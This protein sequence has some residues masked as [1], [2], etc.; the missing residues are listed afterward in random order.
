MCRTFGIDQYKQQDYRAQ[1]AGDDVQ[2]RKMMSRKERLN[3]F[4]FL[5]PI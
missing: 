2:K 5:R 4:S 3:T 1:T